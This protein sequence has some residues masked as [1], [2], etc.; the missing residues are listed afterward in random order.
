MM[1][2]TSL[3]IIPGQGVRHSTTV[4][5]ALDHELLIFLLLPDVV[6][7]HCRHQVVAKT[8]HCISAQALGD[9]LVENHPWLE[10]GLPVLQRSHKVPGC[11][12]S[13]LLQKN[14][15]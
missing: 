6:C 8:L 3:A 1:M 11:C 5:L 12:S 14:C 7:D 15:R 13:T 9:T 2:R 10:V 4:L